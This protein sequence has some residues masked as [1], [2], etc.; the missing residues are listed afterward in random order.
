MS[1]KE[2]SKKLRAKKTTKVTPAKKRT[3]P[4]K[5]TQPSATK[6]ET[7]KD[8]LSLLAL[9]PFRFPLDVE[10]LAV[11]SVRIGGIAF[12]FFGIL[13]SYHYLE[14][15]MIGIVEQAEHS[16]QVHAN[17]ASGSK[18]T[19][20]DMTPEID[21]SYEHGTDGYILRFDVP[22]AKKVS[23]YAFEVQTGTYHKLGD[24]EQ[25]E[26]SD[27]KY[28]WITDSMDSGNY[29]IKVLVTNS[30]GVYDRSDSQFISVQ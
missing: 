5:K 22:Y 27:W 2:E 6:M 3:D 7:A 25:I 26:A 16:A 9:S 15:A 30:Y 21:F 13:F 23:V 12:V 10:K 17:A 28:V 14:S 29:W 20:T 4:L 11:Q 19:Q 18:Y 1:T 8:R 24:A